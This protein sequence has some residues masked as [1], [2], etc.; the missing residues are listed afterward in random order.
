M[1]LPHRRFCRVEFHSMKS[2]FVAGCLAA[3]LPGVSMAAAIAPPRL[4]VAISV[5]Q[6]SAD[7]YA[8]YRPLFT[9]GLRRLGTGAVFPSGFQSHA[10]TETCPGH[11]TILTGSHPAR[12]GIIANDWIDESVARADKTVYCAEDPS[13]PGTSSRAYTASVQYL[14]AQTLGDR[15]KAASPRNRMISVAGKDRA[16]LMLGGHST[17]QVWFWNKGAFVTLAARSGDAP[18]AVDGVNREVAAQIAKPARAVL[19]EACRARAV[20][21]PVGD[22]TVGTLD[23]PPPK[24]LLAFQTSLAFD[25]A[26]TDLAIGLIRELRLGQ[27]EASDVLAIGLSATDYV[28]HTFGTEGAEMCAQLLGVDQNVG[29]ILDALDAT[30]AP[31]LVVLTADHGGHDVAERNRL[32]GIADS[33]R[34]DRALLPASL[35]RTLAGEFGIPE[36]V[37]LGTGV[38]GDF[39]VAR[40]LP[41]DLRARVLESARAH[42]LADPQVEAVFTAAELRRSGASTGPVDEWSLADRFRASFDPERS[43]DLLVA[44]KPHVSSLTSTDTYVATH[45]SPWNYDRRVPILF[46]RPGAPGFEQPLPIETVDILPTIATQIGLPI[47]AGEI[48]GR[49]IELGFSADARCPL[50]GRR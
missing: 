25:R 39:Y 28:G 40:G 44:L 15:L 12:T 2:L 34:A 42:L 3:A 32:H 19:P 31:Y 20:A 43:G 37:L 17:D 33:V 14:K 22:R 29:R 24:G 46:Y 8:E 7:L 11:S 49:C 9:A 38:S 10:A 50:P 30:H 23:H 27:G 4:V 1:L 18:A 36:P 47:P 26:T 16:A 35:G 41:A 5:D 13:V 21:V 45:G 48:D 6:F